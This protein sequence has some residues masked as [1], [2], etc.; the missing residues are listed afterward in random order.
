MAYH[1]IMN[2]LEQS[3][4]AHTLH[5][6]TEVRT[7]DD[8][9]RLVPH[10]TRNLLKTIVFEIKDRGW[11]L[12]VV[13]GHDRIDYKLLA[14]ACETNRKQIRSVAPETVEEKLGFEVGG[15]G[16]FPDCLSLF[17]RPAD[18]PG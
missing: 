7:I 8:A 4:L 11:V 10:L 17:K 13:T 9:E 5:T 12:A 1:T 6:H 2:M 18:H 15:I 16:P 14:R 3:G